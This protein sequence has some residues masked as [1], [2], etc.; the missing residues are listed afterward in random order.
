MKLSLDEKI[1]RTKKCLNLFRNNL[2]KTTD[3]ERIKKLKE[4]I[5]EEEE[6]LQ[7]LIDKKSRAN[8]VIIPQYGDFR[9]AKFLCK[10]AI[11]MLRVK[12]YELYQTDPSIS[13]VYGIN[14]MFYDSTLNIPVY[15]YKV[16]GNVPFEIMFT[17][18]YINYAPCENNSIAI[19]LDRNQILNFDNEESVKFIIN[20][21]KMYS[22]HE[23]NFI[24]DDIIAYIGNDYFKYSNKY[25]DF[26]NELCDNTL[27]NITYIGDTLKDYGN[28][29]E[30]NKV[31]ARF[32]DYH[33]QIK[34]EY[35]DMTLD[36]LEDENRQ[37]TQMVLKLQKQ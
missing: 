12:Y 6:E 37:I 20:L 1:E 9:Y 22:G 28:L 23:I 29:D 34:A 4:I 5:K 2:N 35:R 21:I 36:E 19:K 26:F 7:R 18:Y 8:K 32:V 13:E 3:E 15:P 16:R 10:N 25:Y 31:N 30:I 27:R 33:H 24:C 14:Y 17:D 11:D